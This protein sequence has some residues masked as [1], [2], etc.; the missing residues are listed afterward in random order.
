MLSGAPPCRTG[1]IPAPWDSVVAA[2][3]GL[4]AYFRGVKDASAYLGR[5]GPAGTGTAVPGEPGPSEAQDLR[6]GG[7]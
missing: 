3:I 4:A 2:A 1:L 5:T 6:S 7:Q